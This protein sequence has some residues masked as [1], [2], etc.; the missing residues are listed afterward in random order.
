[1][2]YFKH[3][4]LVN[5][6]DAISTN[7]MLRIR[8]KEK[9]IQNA[10]LYYPYVVKDFERPDTL[11]NQFY[12]NYKY[13]WIVFFSNDIFDPNEEWVKDYNTFLKYLDH[14]YEDPTG[15]RLGS[16]YA[17]QL[18]HEYIGER[19]FVLDWTTWSNDVVQTINESYPTREFHVDEIL[20]MMTSVGTQ[21]VKV[22]AID[23]GAT[24]WRVVA[25]EPVM[26]LSI[27]GILSV[28]L[29]NKY[30]KTKYR[31]EEDLNESRRHIKLIEKRFVPTILQ[32]FKTLLKNQKDDA[33]KLIVR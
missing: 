27:S 16:E 31:Y 8:F 33:R 13:T 24:P 15:N 5:Y 21:K 9:I 17:T 20:N 30:V 12:G 28:P 2:E 1:M 25:I 10:Y 32:E 11:A 29:G 22:T 3:F 26:D 6:D 18:V 7:I 4:P 19:G 23:E 14:K